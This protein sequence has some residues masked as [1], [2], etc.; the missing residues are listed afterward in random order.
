VLNDIALV[1]L[2][3]MAVLNDGVRL[4]C[5]PLGQLL[6]KSHTGFSAL[7]FCMDQFP[8]G[9]WVLWHFQIFKKILGDIHKWIL[10]TGVN[11]IRNK[12]EKFWARIFYHIMFLMLLGSSIVIEWFFF[13]NK[14][15]ISRCR[16]ANIGSTV[17]SPVQLHQQLINCWHRWHQ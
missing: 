1:K 7:S 12:W 10:I 14:K 15:I 4:A 16:Q 9:P 6:R 13:N 11:D 17:L 8:P 5:L 3:R 2:S